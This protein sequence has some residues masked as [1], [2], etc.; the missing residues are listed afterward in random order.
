MDID[1]VLEVSKKLK[2]TLQQ[3]AGNALAIAV[4]TGELEDI[5]PKGGWF[6]KPVFSIF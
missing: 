3:A 6:P 5:E 4:Q 1:Y 2:R